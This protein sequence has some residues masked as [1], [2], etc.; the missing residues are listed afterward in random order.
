MTDLRIGHLP[1]IGAGEFD[2]SY[3]PVEYDEGRY[4]IRCI[5]NYGSLMVDGQYREGGIMWSVTDG[6][7]EI[8]LVGQEGDARLILMAEDEGAGVSAMAEHSV[9]DVTYVHVMRTE[10]FQSL[11]DA[12]GETDGLGGQDWKELVRVAM[13]SI[14]LVATMEGLGYSLG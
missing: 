6:D 9:A 11:M 1:T 8:R 3:V 7:K 12:I 13:K 14:D 5:V 10:M 4:H 2:T